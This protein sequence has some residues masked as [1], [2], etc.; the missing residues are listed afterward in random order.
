MGEPTNETIA[1]VQLASAAAKHRAATDRCACGIPNR[2]TGGTERP[3]AECF[4][5][6]CTGNKQEPCGA[7]DR[8]LVYRFECTVAP[9]P[10]R[11]V[12]KT[13]DGTQLAT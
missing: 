12:A 7:I 10:R 4:V 13:N 2:H 1:G 3:P 6:N 9:S 8:I 5:S 11:A